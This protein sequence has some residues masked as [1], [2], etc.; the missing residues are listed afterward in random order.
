MVV[1][2]EKL[3]KKLTALNKTLDETV[4]LYQKLLDKQAGGEALATGEE[5]IASKQ[6]EIENWKKAADA[7]MADSKR[8]IGGHHSINYNYGNVKDIQNHIDKINE[9]IFRSGVNSKEDLSKLISQ[10]FDND[11]VNN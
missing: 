7:K 2:H 3:E 4:T 10:I 6:K 1:F 5:E 8:G 11:T 9:Y